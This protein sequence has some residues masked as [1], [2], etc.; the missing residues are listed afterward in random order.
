VRT[1]RRAILKPARREHVRHDEL[2]GSAGSRRILDNDLRPTHEMGS[3]RRGRAFVGCRRAPAAFARGGRSTAKKIIV[4]IGTAWSTPGRRDA[5]GG[6]SSNGARP[7]TWSDCCPQVVGGVGEGGE[8]SRV[9]SLDGDDQRHAADA[10]AVSA[11]R[12]MAP[13]RAWPAAAS[14]SR[15]EYGRPVH[16]GPALVAG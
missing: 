2:A 1:G 14:R 9:D 7:R 3:S 10:A 4:T 13:A 5:V 15:G 11:L 6:V 16:S 12:A 8:R